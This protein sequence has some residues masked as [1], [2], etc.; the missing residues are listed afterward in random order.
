MQIDSF[1]SIDIFPKIQLNIDAVDQTHS[2]P[3]SK[4]WNALW[5]KLWV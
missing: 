4:W 1:H 3:D 5:Q 2:D